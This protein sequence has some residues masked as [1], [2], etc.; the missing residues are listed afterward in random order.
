MAGHR[1]VGTDIATDVRPLGRNRRRAPT[2][3]LV[4]LLVGGLAV[5][6]LRLGG[7]DGGTGDGATR[8]DPTSVFD[9][10]A[11]GEAPDGFLQTVG[12]DVIEPIYEA[13][14]RVV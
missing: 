5:A 13:G 8:R 14:V 3:A 6:R 12:R 10:V 11:A 2:V 7:A 4:L 1:P 9:P